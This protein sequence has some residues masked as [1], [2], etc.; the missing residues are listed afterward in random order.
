MSTPGVADTVGTSTT[1]TD[2]TLRASAQHNGLQWDAGRRRGDPLAPLVAVEEQFAGLMSGEG[3]RERGSL[4]V[5]TRCRSLDELDSVIAHI[6]AA[7]IAD[8]TI[9]ILPTS[10][11]QAVDKRYLS[12]LCARLAVPYLQRLT[13]TTPVERD[14]VSALSSFLRRSKGLHSVVLEGLRLVQDDI[15]ALLAAAEGSDTLSHICVARSVC[16]SNGACGCACAAAPALA[17]HGEHVRRAQATVRAAI[18][19]TRIL[20]RARP[21]D[22]VDPEAFPLL[23]MPGELVALVV[24]HCSADVGAL[25]AAQWLKLFTHAQD[26]ESLGLVANGVRAALID[27]RSVDE[28]RAQWLVNGGF[29]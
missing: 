1:P 20:L 24:K 29:W 11:S 17:A 2:L 4:R 5:Q 6:N 7:R 15:G 19:P 12:R 18:V 3:R 13:I 26:P 10:S 28:A 21:S 8:L 16:L 9:S 22:E 14:N 25:T 23:E 27:G